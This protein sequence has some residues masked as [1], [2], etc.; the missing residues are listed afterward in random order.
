MVVF[1]QP[2][3]PHNSGD[4]TPSGHHAAERGIR[5]QEMVLADHVGEGTR[6]QPIGRRARRLVAEQGQRGFGVGHR[7]PWLS[8]A[9]LGGGPW[10]R[11]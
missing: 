1:P 11:S 3:G 10:T 5:G 8:E 4:Q 7:M 9:S 2:G 6:V